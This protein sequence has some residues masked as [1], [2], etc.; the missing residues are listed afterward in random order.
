LCVVNF[1][2]LV[3]QLVFILFVVLVTLSSSSSS[4]STSRIRSF[5]CLFWLQI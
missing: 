4:S 1:K 2:I 3:T 5:Y